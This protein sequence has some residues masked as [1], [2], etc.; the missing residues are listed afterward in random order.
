MLAVE[1]AESRSMGVPDMHYL[2]DQGKGRQEIH[3]GNGQ[4][5]LTTAL[6]YHYT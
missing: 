6:L 3:M 5:I 4:Q 2:N 1:L